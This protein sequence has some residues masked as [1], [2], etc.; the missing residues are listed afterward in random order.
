MS[1]AYATP[2]GQDWYR[3]GEHESSA[4]QKAAWGQQAQAAKQQQDDAW[5]RGREMYERGM[6][7]QEQQRRQYDSETA[8]QMSDKKYDVLSGLL[9]GKMGGSPNFTWPYA[10][11]FSG[12]MGSPAGAM[13][14]TR[15][16]SVGPIG[17]RS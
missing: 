17:G 10:Q 16:R 13:R 14:T 9:N 12:Q 6:Q 4:R 15:S 7:T 5:E 2:G 3:G 8:R 1:M 11:G